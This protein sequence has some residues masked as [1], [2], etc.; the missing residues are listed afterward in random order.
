MANKPI[1]KKI[2]AWHFLRNT[3]RLGY[4]D[5]RKVK[6][7]KWFYSEGKIIL[8]NNGMHASK[9]ILDAY[10]Y[11]PGTILCRV[12]LNDEYISKS[13]DKMVSNA[14]KVLW[15][16]DIMEVIANYTRLSLLDYFEITKKNKKIKPVPGLKSF[17]SKK[18]SLQKNNA[19]AIFN[20]ETQISIHLKKANNPDYLAYYY[21]IIWTFIKNLRITEHSLKDYN[22]KNFKVFSEETLKDRINRNCGTILRLFEYH[23]HYKI[24]EALNKM[25]KKKNVHYRQSSKDLSKILEMKRNKR[26]N[27][28]IIKEIKRQ[29]KKI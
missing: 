14:R 25:L 5:G 6:L 16:I 8:C 1:R 15:W 22:K 19:K 3:K 7:N 24:E 4:K 2:K 18:I 21:D 9:R 29:G 26:L 17:L 12:E 11:A 20:L 10:F 23:S 13:Y 28:M 27:N